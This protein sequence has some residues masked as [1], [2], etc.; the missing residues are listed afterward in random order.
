MPAFHSSFHMQDSPVVGNIAVLPIQS[1]FRGPAPRLTASTSSEVLDIVDEALDLFKA[2]CL[3][4]NF[5]FRNNADRTLVY[6]ILYI[7]SCL[8]KI[9]AKPTMSKQE[10]LKTLM[11]HAA[12]II[13]LPGDPAFPLNSI[14]VPP[15][16][17]NEQDL[18]RQYITQ[19]R[20]ETAVRL[21]GRIYSRDEMVPSKVR[22][23]KLWHTESS[24]FFVVA[25]HR[26]SVVVVV[27]LFF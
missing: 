4:K 21:L 12:S 23:R 18:M 8:L 15:S 9:A 16:N 25:S 14:F 7:H 24:F 11:Q 13:A 17:T 26:V 20:Q 5:E 1:E 22:K 19:L 6:L 3:F 10:A 27:A 2:N